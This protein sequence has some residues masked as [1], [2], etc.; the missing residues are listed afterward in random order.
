MDLGVPPTDMND[1]LESNPP[2]SRFLVHELTVHDSCNQPTV[3]TTTVTVQL[4]VNSVLI[5]YFLIE[6]HTR[7][8]QHMWLKLQWLQSAGYMNDM[9]ILPGCILDSE[10]RQKLLSGPCCGDL[11]LTF[12]PSQEECFFTDTSIMNCVLLSFSCIFPRVSLSG[13]VFSSRQGHPAR[14][15]IEI[16]AR[17]IPSSYH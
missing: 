2:G 3:T 14:K 4:F 12:L 11:K 9:S 17:E 6:V 10:N 16:Q 8:E 13:G 15:D 7:L 1:L 5:G